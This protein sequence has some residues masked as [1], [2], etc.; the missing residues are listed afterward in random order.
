LLKTFADEAAIAIDNARLIQDLR[1]KT[2]DLEKS[3]SDLHKALEQQTATSEILRVIASSRRTSNLCCDTV[4]ANAARL[5]DAENATILRVQDNRFE[6]VSV[7]GLMP[8]SPAPPPIDR[9][10]AAGARAVVEGRTIHVHD[11]A[12]QMETEFPGLKTRQ[13]L[14]G[15][16]TFLVTP[17]LREGVAIGAI[18]IRRSEVRPFSPGQIKLLENI[19]QT[20]Q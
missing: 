8:H 10:D 15:I 9:E 1:Q 12:A 20:K 4:A 17:L 16:R 3:N 11:A 13:P 7:Y 14:T 19:L 2:S 18:Q 6:R 5:C